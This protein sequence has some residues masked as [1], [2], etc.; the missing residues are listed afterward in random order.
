MQTAG[1]FRELGRLR[2]PTAQ[3]SIVTSISAPLPDA[4]AVVGYLRSGHRLIMAMD[5]QPDVV[6]GSE[7]ILN[8]SSVVTDGDWLWREDLAYYL[9]RH[10]VGLPEEFLQLIRE[11]EYV[12]PDVDDTTLDQAAA[13]AEQLLSF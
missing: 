7:Q 9:H 13:E 4:D 5:V 11:R 1:M 12:V 2:P 8:G 6:D 3:P 10:H